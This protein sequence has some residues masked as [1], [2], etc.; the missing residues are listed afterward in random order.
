MTQKERILMLDYA[1]ENSKDDL[2]GH[3]R[4]M[5]SAYRMMDEVEEKGNW[6]MSFTYK[7]K[8]SGPRFEP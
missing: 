8:R 6:N 5:S 3:D 1:S 4:R 7:M 2:K